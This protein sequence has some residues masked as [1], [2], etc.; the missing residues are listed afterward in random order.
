MSLYINKVY[1]AIKQTG[2]SPDFF[3]GGSAMGNKGGEEKPLQRVCFYFEVVVVMGLFW[4]NSDG[5][6]GCFGAFSARLFLS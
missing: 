5:G 1:E 2:L 3:L 6:V 4:V